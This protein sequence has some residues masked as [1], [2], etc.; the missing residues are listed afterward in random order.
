M[1]ADPLLMVCLLKNGFLNHQSF[2][3][4]EKW[5]FKNN[6]YHLSI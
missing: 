1:Q 4:T 2:G 6:V 5:Y 3:K